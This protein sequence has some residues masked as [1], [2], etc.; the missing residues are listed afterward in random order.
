MHNR[1]VLLGVVGISALAWSVA[2]SS[3]GDTSTG[4]GAGA[5]A[6][7]PGGPGTGSVVNGTGAATSG[8]TTGNLGGAPNTGGTDAGSGGYGAGITVDG[9]GQVLCGDHVC[10]CADG[11][12]NDGD[13]VA[14]GFDI[15]CTGPADDDE[16]SF[17]TGIPGDN[18]DPKQD[19]FFDGDSGAGND[20]CKDRENPSEQC[21]AFCAPR[22]SNGCDCFGCCQITLEGG[23]TT[24]VQLGGTCTDADLLGDTSKC[25]PCKQS[26]ACMNTCG[27]CELC[28]GKT[29]EDLP[30]SCEG[31]VPSCDN[32]ELSCES[33]A[34]C[35]SGYCQLGCCVPLIIK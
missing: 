25:K 14:D 9:G 24:T 4:G 28:P 1:L 3:S 6:G 21:I 16:S 17:A 27:E 31:G 18:K 2:C 20:G 30:E 32:P 11:I 34:D 7:S 8:G 29:V 10:Q 33:S 23:E 19:C 35:S 22:T 5:Q 13:G 26:E 15:E 12:D